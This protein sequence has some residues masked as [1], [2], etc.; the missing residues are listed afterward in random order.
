MLDISRFDEIESINPKNFRDIK[1]F[2]CSGK[3]L[4]LLLMLKSNEKKANIFSYIKKN[5]EDP[6]SVIS[7]LES[8]NLI[9]V[10]IKKTEKKE[11]KKAPLKEPS[12]DI[13]ELINYIKSK[14]LES[15]GPIAEVI[16]D[17]VLDDMG[18]KKQSFN[19]KRIPELIN[20]LSRE[21]PRDDKRI[22]FQRAMIA[23]LKKF[24]MA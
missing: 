5:I 24:K 14:F 23:M 15:V 1:T 7:K 6:V 11:L 19:I 2:T 20:F 8:Y 22:E 3:E 17:D 18:E 12:I 16:F 4:E 13:S 21:I 9:D 10:K